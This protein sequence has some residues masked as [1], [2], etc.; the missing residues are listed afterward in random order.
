MGISTVKKT[1]QQEAGPGRVKTPTVFQMEVSECGAASLA[2]ILQYYGRYVPLEE[3][4]VET[5]VSR[6]GC[7]AKNICLAAQKYG[8][9]TTGSLRDLDR[10]VKKAQLPCMLHWNASHFVV[11]EGVHRGKYYINDPAQGRRILSRKEMEEGYSSVVLTMTP[12]PDFVKSKNRRT[13]V[14]FGLRRLQGERKTLLALFLMGLCLIAPGI[15]SSLFPQVFLD[16][17]LA[18]GVY[19]WMGG[20]LILMLFTALFKGYFY[21]LK[22]RTQLLLQGKLTLL[23]S[24]E[25]LTHMLRLPMSFFEQRFAGDLV[26]RVTNNASVCNFLAGKLVGLAISLVTSLVYLLLMLQYS[27]EMT[28]VA[29][30]FM[31]LTMALIWLSAGRIAVCTQKYGQDLGKLVGNLYCGL[32]VSDSI[33]AAG[34]E[35]EYAGKLLG[36]YAMVNASDQ[37]LEAIQKKLEVVPSALELFNRILLLLIGS[38]MV[39]QGNLSTGMVVAFTGFL[40]SFSQPL[41]EVVD[42]IRSIGQVKNDMGRVE[43]IM[44]YP[45]DDALVKREEKKA[46]RTVVSEHTAVSQQAAAPEQENAQQSAAV[47]EQTVAPKQTAVVFSNG[48]LRGEIELRDISYAYGKLDKPFIRKFSCHIEPGKSVALVG[49]SGSGKSTVAKMISSLYQ[50][51]SGEMLFDGIPAAQV[52]EEVLHNSICVVSQN[53]ALFKGSIY[54]NITLWNN[55]IRQEDVILAAK[56]ACIHEEITIKPAAYDYQ[57]NESGSNLSGGQR[58]RIE[59][60]KA[61]VAKPS[62][63]VLDEATSALDTVTEKTI[64]DNIRKRHCTCVIVAQRL[65]TIRDCDEIIVM[66]KGRIAERGSHAELIAMHGK[67]EKMVQNG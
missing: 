35:N 14:G 10:M 18:E 12:G 57:I 45:E 66:D 31:A 30:V 50:P 52:P 25:M 44:K 29:V 11:F 53:V 26:Q 60:A 61:L 27:V 67:Y 20:L 64:L 62:I 24:D 33:K 6:N 19:S 38:T 3:L 34:A 54:E 2:M 21:Y 47:P 15:L 16:E 9:E 37:E 7:N 51:W 59:I 1:Q 55:H 48:R 46:M 58:Q 43:D 8:L 5:G 17:I 65:S 32:T 36:Y 13:L 40:A 39:I 63:L 4:R 56:D 28:L 49:A 22:E 41:T 23:S 42:F